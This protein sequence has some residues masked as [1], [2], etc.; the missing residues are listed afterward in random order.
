MAPLLD[1]ASPDFWENPYPSYRRLREEAPV[2]FAEPIQA[3]LVSRYTDVFAALTD[4]RLSVAYTDAFYLGLPDD[5]LR[6][7]DRLRAALRTA[8]IFSD[9]PHH[10]RMRE[11]LRRSFTPVYIEAFRKSAVRIAGELTGEALTRGTLDVKHN[12]CAVLPAAALAEHL[13]AARP[14]VAKL[15]AWGHRMLG[16]FGRLPH[17][18]ALAEDT[19]RTYD[20]LTAYFEGLFAAY[21]ED[22][23]ESLLTPL[24][25]AAPSDAPASGDA[26]GGASGSDRFT[27]DELTMTCIALLVA[28]IETVSNLICGMIVTLDRH[29]DELA[30][31]RREPELLPLAIDELMR[32]DSPIQ[33]T[34]RVVR[35]PLEIG[36]Q[37]LLPGQRVML[38]IGSANRDPE[39]AQDPDR[40]DIGRRDTRHLAFGHGPHYCIGA[41]LARLQAQEVLSAFYLKGRDVRVVTS[42]ILWEPNL[43]HRSVRELEVTFV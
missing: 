35:E 19:L 16:F 9:P 26:A 30:R 41:Q 37:K 20:E 15:A 43:V 31:L 17:D 21:R 34:F 4:P 25:R 10:D 27:N 42:P 12:F 33:S 24:L 36:G 2:H 38:L 11:L 23:R 22:P 13:G 7:F 29:P 5:L 8:I 40:F 39:H 14:D 1:L 6:R 3:W 18:I 32:F 28:G